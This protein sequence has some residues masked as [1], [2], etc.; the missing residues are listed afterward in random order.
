MFEEHIC[1]LCGAFQNPDTGECLICGKSYHILDIPNM[2]E[3]RVIGDFIVPLPT[4]FL[5]FRAFVEMT[6]EQETATS[7]LR[8][9]KEITL[10]IHDTAKLTFHFLTEDDK[11]KP[12]F[13]IYTGRHF[14]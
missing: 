12:L 4:G 14:S 10:P 11:E 8:N 9:G 5:T 6:M 1:P 2:M 7:V 3:G 13:R